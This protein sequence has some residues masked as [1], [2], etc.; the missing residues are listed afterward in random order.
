MEEIKQLQKELG[1]LLEEENMKWRQR[2]NINWYQKG[3]RN[4]KF[5]NACA[6]QRRKN[7]SLLKII[8]SQN[9]VRTGEAGV[10]KAF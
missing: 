4:T 6:T 5:F 1:N 7:N 2:A 3:D 10:R 8:Y 9:Q